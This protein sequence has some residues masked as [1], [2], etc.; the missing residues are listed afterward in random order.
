[1]WATDESPWTWGR[2]RAKR[3]GWDC[4][5][6][7]TCYICR[8]P[9]PQL[10]PVKQH[11]GPGARRPCLQA[12]VSPENSGDSDAQPAWKWTDIWGDGQVWD[13]LLA[14]HKEGGHARK[15]LRTGLSRAPGAPLFTHTCSRGPSRLRPLFLLA[16]R[17]PPATSLQA[18]VTTASS[19]QGRGPARPA[20]TWSRIWEVAV[21]SPHSSPPAPGCRDRPRGVGLRTQRTH[22]REEPPDGGSHLPTGSVKEHQ[23]PCFRVGTLVFLL[24]QPAGPHGDRTWV[25]C[26]V[27]HGEGCREARPCE[28][29]QAFKRGER[30]AHLQPG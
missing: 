30:T 2:T 3:R 14:G 9:R 19:P 17:A 18:A 28:Q 12:S 5:T 26:R 11:R 21:P 27:S 4:W 22:P 6:C 10:G 7:R 24:Q 8:C 15:V 29:S 13:E 25:T 1:M 20:S 16:P 23:R